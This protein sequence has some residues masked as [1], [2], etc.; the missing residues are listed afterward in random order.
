MLLL[1]LLLLPLSNPNSLSKILTAREEAPGTQT[2][3]FATQL[4]IARAVGHASIPQHNRIEAFQI[5][6][7]QRAH[8]TLIRVQTGEEQGA[9]IFPLQ[10]FGAFGH[11]DAHARAA[12]LV[13]V[14]IGAGRGLAVLVRSCESAMHP[15]IPRAANHDP[16]CVDLGAVLERDLTDRVSHAFLIPVLAIVPV[17]FACPELVLF[18]T[19]HRVE[20]KGAVWAWVH[21]LEILGGVPSGHPHD[22]DLGFAGCWNRILEEG[23]FAIKILL[24]VVSQGSGDVVV[25]IIN[26]QEGCFGWVDGDRGHFTF[27]L[28]AGLNGLRLGSR[29][30]G[31]V[32]ARLFAPKSRSCWRDRGQS[33]PDHREGWFGRR[34]YL[35]A[36]WW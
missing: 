32:E 23:L 26:D 30:V 16:S 17:T 20:S 29:W 10:V 14:N 7:L 21:V 18:L 31:E 1:L 27:H 4:S 2:I 22:L 3:D 11:L 28:D 25:L 24:D 8:H 33:C 9:E 34:G 13:E 36:F 35:A 5:G 12:V 19:Q 6:I 15:A